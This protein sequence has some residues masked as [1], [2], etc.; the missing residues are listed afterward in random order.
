M[1]A[2][3][4]AGPKRT[5]E[6]GANDWGWRG[7]GRS[8]EPGRSYWRRGRKRIAASEAGLREGGGPKKVGGAK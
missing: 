7:A 4:E 1:G 5:A 3:L 2:G 8:K 6:V